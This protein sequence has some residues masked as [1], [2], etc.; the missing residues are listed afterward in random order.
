MFIN[1]RIEERYGRAPPVRLKKVQPENIILGGKA[2]VDDLIEP[3]T[4]EKVLY[5]ALK[6]L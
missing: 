4:C 5:L 6:D 3:T 2:E 1:E